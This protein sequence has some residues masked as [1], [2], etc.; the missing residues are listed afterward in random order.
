MSLIELDDL[1]VWYR[2]HRL[3][4]RRRPP[5]R[6]VDGIS[7]TIGD[8][9]VVGL[10]GESGSGK[11]TLG[12]AILKLVAPTG[13][14]LRYRGEDL[15]DPPRERLAEFRRSVQ[16]VFQDPYSSF[17]P[18]LRIVDVVGEPLRLQGVARSVVRRRAGEVLDAVG[19]EAEALDRYP[20]QFSGG[21]RQRIAIAR[22]LIVS[23]RLIVLDEPVASL[24]VSIRGQVINLLGDLREELDV[25]LLLISHD[26]PTT[27]HLSDRI[28]VMYAGRSIEEGPADD[29]Y[30]RPIHPYTRALLAAARRADEIGA[31]LRVQGEPPDPRFPPAGCR[32]HPRCPWAMEV[33]VTSEPPTVHR[34]AAWARCHLYAPPGPDEQ[35]VPLP[36]RRT[37]T[38]DDLA[39][40]VGP[41]LATHAPNHEEK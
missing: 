24:D 6:A 18:R 41:A 35:H 11:S 27:R 31:E 20:H 3:S 14:S 13:G 28:H 2:D 30:E 15:L 16:A 26:L 4:P 8:D 40:G 22:A 9:E 12:R 5:V 1:H 32:F 37:P 38:P 34:G 33:C 36:G 23:P 17:N 39:T 7:L 19:I 21:Q 29:V 10:V 25:S